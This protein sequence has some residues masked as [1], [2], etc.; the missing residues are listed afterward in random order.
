MEALWLS[1]FA[2]IHGKLSIAGRS[3]TGEMNE[4]NETLFSTL[5]PACRQAGAAQESGEWQERQ[6]VDMKVARLAP[7]GLRVF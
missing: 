1:R 4:T 7:D 3:E 6:P 2:S 5:Q